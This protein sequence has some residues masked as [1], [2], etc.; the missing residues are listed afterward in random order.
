M[1]VII[2]STANKK[3][4]FEAANE[5]RNSNL[6]KGITSLGIIFKKVAN[7]LILM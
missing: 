7:T 1:N 3:K 6:I 4:A 2:K 5:A